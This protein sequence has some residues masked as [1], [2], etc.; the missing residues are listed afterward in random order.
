M[1]KTFRLFI[2]FALM[3]VSVGVN[4]QKTLQRIVSEKDALGIAIKALGDDAVSDECNYYI[5]S[6]SCQFEGSRVVVPAWLVFVDMQPGTGWEHDCMYVFVP[7][8]IPSGK[9]IVFK[10]MSQK[11]PPQIA[12]K[13]LLINK[14]YSA[15][16]AQKKILV[17]K[18]PS[19]NAAYTDSVGNLTHAVIIS[20]GLSPM[21]N[22]G[23]YWNDCSFIYQTL[24]NKYSV[25]AQNI[26][27]IMADGTDPAVDM[28]TEDTYGLVSS[29]TDLDGDGIADIKYAAS[30][31]N[32][33]KVF[34]DMAAKLEDKDHLFV[35]VIDHG[36]YDYATGRSYIC[37]WNGEKLYDNELAEYLKPVD[38]GFI[39]IVLG[40]C[41]SGGFVDDLKGNNRLIATA[42]GEFE[43]SY[44]SPMIPFDEFVYRWT[45][46][47]S[48]SDGFG[49][50][51][52]TGASTNETITMKEAFE[53]AERVGI[54]SSGKHSIVKETPTFSYLENSVAEVLAFN[55]IPP[56][57]YLY[58]T[59]G[60]ER[61]LNNGN[62]TE[63]GIVNP[64][65]NDFAEINI[66]PF[67]DSSDI[68]VRN[69]NDGF[70]IQEHENA[71]ITYYGDVIYVYVK[72]RNKGVKPYKGKGQ[73][74][75]M[76]WAKSALSIPKSV[77][78]GD[79]TNTENDIYGEEISSGVLRKE[80]GPG[81]SEIIMSDYSFR[82]EYYTAVEEK[83][84]NFN[85]CILACI[86]DAQNNPMGTFITSDAIISVWGTDKLAQKNKI[87]P[88]GRVFDRDS[89][90]ATCV[91]MTNF[92][93]AKKSYKLYV[94]N[95][96]KNEG[97]FKKADVYLNMQQGLFASWKEGGLM[98]K[99]FSAD[100]NVVGKFKVLDAGTDG[101]ANEISNIV[102]QPYQSGKI[103]L[104]YNFIADEAITEEKTYDVDVALI[105]EE[106]GLCLG[107]ET[108][109][110]KQKPR[111]AIDLGVETVQN[112]D[113][114]FT[115]QATNVSESVTYEWY[116]ASGKLV[117]KG[118]TLDVPAGGSVG[119]YTVKVKSASDGAVNYSS[120][121]LE[122]HSKIKAVSFDGAANEVD[123]TLAAPA[124]ADTT[125]RLS[126]MSG[127]VPSRDGNVA[128]GST[129]CSIP[130]H[131]LGNGVY[132]VSL[133]EGGK[134]METKKFIK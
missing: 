51:I 88:L 59:S 47:I 53:Y 17:E 33:R 16:V 110:I 111:P 118:A 40:Q 41:N 86:S 58:T 100:A 12:M 37:L 89:D 130:A 72:V 52:N 11:A 78:L 74:L 119:E 122:R 67:W 31:E 113:G 71:D 115:L 68:W 66:H 76:F 124:G 49:N 120:T 1:K 57:V 93:N 60:E 129:S 3:L 13:S 125:L 102:M 62:K 107:G 87:D 106:T 19:S 81:C 128:E 132:Q 27:T 54:Y 79:L 96:P 36:G 97:L 18:K 64:G 28:L 7:K 85:A 114:T 48:E 55:N 46:A 63:T 5:A 56:T 50:Y 34:G 82:N 2:A 14:R 121:A 38:A 91:G 8:T 15:D 77:W 101:D 103:G 94:L 10:S 83:G 20:G 29:P 45:C 25:P 123:V 24:R 39:N 108:F 112:A 127:N 104:E 69:Q 30:K 65:I 84:K 92:S 134:V 126:S 23:R 43:S 109:V 105:D 116:D 75:S 42:C 70:E 9:E 26:H 99:N 80:I 98:R 6:S 35:F 21:A 73:Y 61:K 22:H 95:N 90:V 32:I 4:A 133:I 44:A 131:G 117:G